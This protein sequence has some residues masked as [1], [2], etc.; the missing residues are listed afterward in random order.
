MSST[1]N[2][3]ALKID[4][5]NVLMSRAPLRRM[6]AEPLR[7]SLLQIGGQLDLKVGGTI[8]AFENY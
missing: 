4:P 6:E 8:W 2:A 3:A 1:P 5:T 7:D